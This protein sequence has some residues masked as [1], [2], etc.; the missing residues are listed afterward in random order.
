MAYFGVQRANGRVY[1]VRFV[2][3]RDGRIF[4][5][6]IELRKNHGY[7]FDILD[8]A[9]PVFSSLY[10]AYNYLK[11]LPGWEKEGVLSPYREV[12]EDIMKRQEHKVTAGKKAVAIIETM[13]VMGYNERKNPDQ[14]ERVAR[15]SGK[16]FFTTIMRKEKVFT[17]EISRHIFSNLKAAH[18]FLH[19]LQGLD[20]Q[21]PPYW[22]MQYEMDVGREFSIKG[23]GFFIEGKSRSVYP[24]SLIHI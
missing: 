1:Y 19:T 21:M 23:K 13:D 22:R 16:V 20:I 7:E 17:W 3:E 6:K 15:V 12:E 11:S 18:A 8:G 9:K 10:A 14:M 5:R 24:L 4:T 2:E